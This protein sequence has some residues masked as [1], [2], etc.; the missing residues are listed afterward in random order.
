LSKSFFA[1]AFVG[2]SFC[3]LLRLRLLAAFLRLRSFF[4]VE[5]DH[6]LRGGDSADHCACGEGGG[7]E[8]A[9]GDQALTKHMSFPRGFGSAGG[10]L[11]LLA[12]RRSPCIYEKDQ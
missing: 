4:F 6:L 2:S 10:V 7:G 12:H 9:T 8:D 1:D 5:I 3:C 11:E